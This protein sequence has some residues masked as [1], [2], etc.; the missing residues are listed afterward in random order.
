MLG[1]YNNTKFILNYTSNKTS[2]FLN[3]FYEQILHCSFQVESPIYNLGQ[4]KLGDP[5]ELFYFDI[6]PERVNVISL[7]WYVKNEV[8]IH[9]C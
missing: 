2:V 1:Q 8:G 3:I 7:G 4:Y 9:S 6:I 5:R